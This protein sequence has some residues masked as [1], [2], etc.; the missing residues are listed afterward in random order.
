MFAFFASYTL[1]TKILSREIFSTCIYYTYIL[2]VYIYVY[3]RIRYNLWAWPFV[4]ARK[5]LLLALSESSLVGSRS[6]F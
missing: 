2:Y 6:W 5:L 4:R 3:L 1:T